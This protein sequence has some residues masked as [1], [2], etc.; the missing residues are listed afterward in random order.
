MNHAN[1]YLL[2]NQTGTAPTALVLPN[3]F[4]VTNTAAKTLHLGGN[5]PSSVVN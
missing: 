5:A 3:N 4:G 2:A 1:S